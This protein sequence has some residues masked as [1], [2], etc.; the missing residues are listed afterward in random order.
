M[1]P[2]TIRACRKAL[3]LTQAQF[4][5]AVGLTGSAKGRKVTVS[6]WEAGTQAPTNVAGLRAMVMAAARLLE[7]EAAVTK[8][9]EDAG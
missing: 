9:M 6:R 5:E 3:G 8:A 2:A 7:V 4:G 1:T